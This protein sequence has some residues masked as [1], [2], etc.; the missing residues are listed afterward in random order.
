[1]KK[2]ILITL[3]AALFAAC[4]DSSK[5]EVGAPTADTKTK[6]EYFGEKITEEGAKPTD[7]L[8]A[9]MGNDTMLNCKLIGKI[10][11]VCQKKGCWME[12]KNADGS[13]IRVTFK[14]YGFFMPKDASGRTAIVDGFAKVD[15]TSVAE[16]QEFA[17]DD[18]KSKEQIAAI[19]E[20]KKELVFEAK[21]V[22]LK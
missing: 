9:M 15:V 3:T 16:L 17:K 12:L 20:P 18:G 5:K 22:I 13:S 14:D 6:T 10:D 11:A 4:N 19:T 21:G 1:M 2:L 8:K 7:S